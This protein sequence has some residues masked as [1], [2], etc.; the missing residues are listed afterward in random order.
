MIQSMKRSG[1]STYALAMS[2]C[3]DLLQNT[4]HLLEKFYLRI[5]FPQK[6]RV[7][8]DYDQGR[9]SFF[10]LDRKTLVHAIEHTHRNRVSVF[11]RECKNPSS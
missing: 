2:G 1:A 8:L 3:M 4:I 5:H 9:L 7:V 10:D 6:V 11:L